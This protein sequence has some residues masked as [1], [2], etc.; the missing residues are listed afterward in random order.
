MSSY[1]TKWVI[2]YILYGFFYF[3]TEFEYHPKYWEYYFYEDFEYLI[4]WPFIIYLLFPVFLKYCGHWNIIKWLDK[5]IDSLYQ[6]HK[7]L[8]T[9][10][11]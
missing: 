10:K 3:K 5:H 9:P 4:I 1:H 6:L 2:V 11:S 7:A 8:N